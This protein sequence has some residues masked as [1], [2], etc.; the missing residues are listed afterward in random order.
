MKA[1]VWVA[2]FLLLVSVGGVSAGIILWKHK[3]DRQAQEAAAA[4]MHEPAEVISVSVA[5]E[6]SHRPST[7]AIGTIVALRSVTLRN[8]VAGTVAKVSL[9]PGTIVEAGTP[10]VMQ[11]VSVEQAELRVYEAQAAL[12][13]IMLERLDRLSQKGDQ[14]GVVSV[15]E[16]DRAKTERDVA[17]A[18]IERV[19][20]IIARKTIS[21]P[22]R[23]KVGIADVHVG[24]YLQEGTLLTT[25]QGVDQT[26]YVD[27]AVAQRVA[28]EL[29]PGD[30]LEIVSSLSAAPVVAK[31]NAI[32]SRVDA[33]TRNATIRAEIADASQVPAPG[34][35][36]R[37]RIPVGNV[38]KAVVVPVSALRR[39]P[40]GD[41]VF[42]IAKAQDG[43]NRAQL[44]VVQS[45]AVLGNEVL[46]RSGLAAGE[47]VA[48][49]GS[50]KLREDVLV[51]IAPATVAAN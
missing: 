24:Q 33:V 34:A 37:V 26:T 14:A 20:A 45:D 7:S 39:G 23:A 25:L 22:F 51:E 35:S 5:Q 9:E 21:A 1:R 6:K 3:K 30:P 40:A 44:R 42:V 43:K 27:F 38:T 18:Q 17:Q 11:D 8:E 12:A 2:S 15:T 28:E 29:H 19:K 4:N 13:E 31:V 47:T 46:I 36:V 41:H 48:S 16:R 32:D 49:S 10:L 50:F